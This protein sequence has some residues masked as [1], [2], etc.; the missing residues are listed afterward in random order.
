MN[1]GGTMDSITTTQEDKATASY[2]DYIE[3]LEVSL[4]YAKEYAANIN[5]VNNSAANYPTINK[6][7]AELAVQRNQTDTALEKQTNGSQ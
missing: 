4:T 1:R 7:R 6:L 5:P 3:G 2:N